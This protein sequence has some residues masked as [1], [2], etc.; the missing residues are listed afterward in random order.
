MKLFNLMSRLQGQGQA[1]LRRQGVKDLPIEMVATK[2]LVNF[3][4]P[5]AKKK[6]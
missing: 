1:E 4:V 3:K 6:N 2:A 5:K